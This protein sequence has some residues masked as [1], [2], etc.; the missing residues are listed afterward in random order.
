MPPALDGLASLVDKSLV[1]RAHRHAEAAGP[2]NEA[3]EPR[4][5]ML[6][7]VREFGQEMLAAAQEENGVRAAHAAHM[8]DLA[9]SRAT[10]PAGEPA[11]FDRMDVELS[12]LRAALAWT[13]G[14]NDP[15]AGL[16]L[17]SALGS[18]WFR[19]GRHREGR[20]WLER[21][22]AGAPEAAPGVQSA[23]LSALG[24][25]RRE[26]GE[27]AGAEHAY[28]SA[29][30]LANLGADRRAEATALTGLATL[31]NDVSDYPAQKACMEASL[32]IWHAL[33]EGH[34]LARALHHLSWAEFGLGNTERALTLVR[35]AH[36]TARV[37][38]DNRWMARALGSWGDMLVWAGDFRAAQPLVD[39]G[40]RVAR[41]AGAWHDV[42]LLAGDVGMITVQLG[43]FP[44]ARA[45]LAESIAL[46][47]E[48]GRKRVTV[49]TLEASAVLAELEAR[50]DLALQL[51]AAATATRAEIGLPIKRDG[52][53][54][55]MLE[56]GRDAVARTLRRLIDES[57]AVAP[58]WSMDEALRHAAELTAPREP[59][60][61]EQR[62]GD[63]GDGALSGLSPRELDVL[64]LVVGGRTDQAIANELFIS[65][66]T[67]SK[68]V[69][70]ILAK[71]DA[72]SRAEAAVRAV[73]DGL[74]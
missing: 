24:D 41:E 36:A 50:H 72:A 30:E 22:L 9:A 60:P 70:A 5:E 20:D 12:N 7:T 8:L 47:L 58:V 39:E 11:W 13:C 71:L 26:L 10:E 16:R 65:R 6:E 44:A 34:E 21:A 38:G 33:G 56:L 25:L 46:L 51:T 35:E 73:R 54:G 32:A 66:R 43:D 49:F 62:R 48:T 57:A 40:L 45:Y 3:I 23:G 18:Y 63:A 74:V 28:S 59:G 1:R 19:S 68:H 64:R 4:F 52:M 17:A 14:G 61:A 67:A 29:L 27:W 42:A 55:M 15:D 2:R 53:I 69:A 31:A 37:A